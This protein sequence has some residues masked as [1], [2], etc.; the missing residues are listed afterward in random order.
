MRSAL[1]NRYNMIFHSRPLPGKT[2]DKKPVTRAFLAKNWPTGYFF[3]KIGLR[4]FLD[5]TITE[6]HAKNQ[7]KN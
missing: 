7:K 3:Q 2:S 1:E 5:I 6:Q 4:Q